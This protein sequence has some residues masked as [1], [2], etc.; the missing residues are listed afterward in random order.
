VGKVERDALL[1]WCKR[2]VGERALLPE[3]PRGHKLGDVGYGLLGRERAK[4][5]CNIGVHTICMGMEYDEMRAGEEVMLANNMYDHLKKNWLVPDGS[6]ALKMKMAHEGAM[7]GDLCVL[8]A[9]GKP[10]GH[11]AVVA[12]VKPMLYSGKWGMYV[13]QVANI[14]MKNGFMGANYAF[15]SIPEVFL[16]GRTLT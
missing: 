2:V 9:K 13:P 14:G 16:L 4:T 11:V 6:P 8:A 7:R 12:P 15:E 5:F 3:D 1:D 10:S